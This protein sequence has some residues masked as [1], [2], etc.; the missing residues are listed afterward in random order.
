MPELAVVLEKLN[1]IESVQIE[2]GSSLKTLSDA[3]VKMAVQ[4]EQIT[5]IQGQLNSLWRKNDE[6]TKPE[7]TIANIKEHQARCPEKEMHRT[8]KWVWGVISIHSGL[9][10]GLFYFLL[11]E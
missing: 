2:K 4:N 9:L 1:N 7:G 11:K 10:M 6:L 3:V 5:S 8:F